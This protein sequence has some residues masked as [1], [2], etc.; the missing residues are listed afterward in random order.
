LAWWIA[1]RLIILRPVVRVVVATL[2]GGV[3]T[4]L[5]FGNMHRLFLDLPPTSPL[6]LP[7]GVGMAAGFAIS[8]AWRRHARHPLLLAAPITLGVFLALIGTWELTLYSY[9][10]LDAPYDPLIYFSFSFESSAATLNDYV[11]A[12][13]GAT[14]TGLCS[15]LLEATRL[16]A[17]LKALVRRLVDP[18]ADPATPEN[19]PKPNFP[20]T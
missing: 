14:L 13:A 20:K 3:V 18:G 10:V 6:L 5:A 7:G 16:R 15:V 2:V 4:A 17:G 8:G 9:Q 19:N 12:L 1:S 11:L